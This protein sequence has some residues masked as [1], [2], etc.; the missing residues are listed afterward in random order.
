MKPKASDWQTVVVRLE[1]YSSRLKQAGIMALVIAT[2][3]L[4]TVHAAQNQVPEDAVTRFSREA[5]TKLIETLDVAALLSPSCKEVVKIMRSDSRHNS[6]SW[7]MDLSLARMIGDDELCRYFITRVQIILEIIVAR[8]SRVSL[9]ENLDEDEDDE[10]MGDIF[11]QFWPGLD[12]SFEDKDVFTDSSGKILLPELIKTREE[13]TQ[14]WDLWGDFQ[15]LSTQ[16]KNWDNAT[17]KEILGSREYDC[18]G[19]TYHSYLA[20]KLGIYSNNPV[21]G[22]CFFPFLYALIEDQGGHFRVLYLSLFSF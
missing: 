21:Y 10:L 1:K 8:L 4:Q 5:E 14:Y 6:D 17:S 3:V 15:G 20:E 9:E 13:L 16:Q 19:L 11:K 2:V 18:G 12:I 22:G 7:G